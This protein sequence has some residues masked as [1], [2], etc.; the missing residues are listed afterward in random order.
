MFALHTVPGS[1]SPRYDTEFTREPRQ[2]DPCEVA[3]FPGKSGPLE[4]AV[5]AAPESFSGGGGRATFRGRKIR[6]RA[7]PL[8]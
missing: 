2:S 6:S 4:S 7:R 3:L 8:N 1:V 5:S